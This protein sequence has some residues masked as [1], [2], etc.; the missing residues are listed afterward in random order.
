MGMRE[1]SFPSTTTMDLLLSAGIF[2]PVLLVCLV[3]RVSDGED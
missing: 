1:K 3:S 2:W